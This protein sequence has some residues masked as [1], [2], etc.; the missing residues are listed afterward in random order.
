[1]EFCGTEHIKSM[2][3]GPSRKEREQWKPNIGVFELCTLSLCASKFSLLLQHWNKKFWED[4]T[5]DA[6]LPPPPPGPTACHS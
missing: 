5:M 3:P 1:M 4:F 2:K 6:K